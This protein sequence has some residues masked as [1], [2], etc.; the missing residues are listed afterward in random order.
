MEE[1]DLMLYFV[2]KSTNPRKKI[3]Y[4]AQEWGKYFTLKASASTA[5]GDGNIT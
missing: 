2:F 3:T 1:E 4:D 5:T